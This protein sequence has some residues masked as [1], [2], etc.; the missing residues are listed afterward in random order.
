MAEKR[1]TRNTSTEPWFVQYV[2]TEAEH[3]AAQKAIAAH[4]AKRAMPEE[5][6]KKAK[7][8]TQEFASMWSLVGHALLD[9]GS[10]LESSQ[11]ARA[12]L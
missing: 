4:E 6:M 11:E 10:M 7:E 3:E 5:W 8:L 9:D 2:Y 12:A 1:Y